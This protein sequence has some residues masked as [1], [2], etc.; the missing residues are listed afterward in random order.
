MDISVLRS[1]GIELKKH[2]GRKDVVALLSQKAVKAGLDPGALPSI[3]QVG[4]VAASG[5]RGRAAEIA[6][7]VR[8]FLRSPR[9]AQ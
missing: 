4:N 7:N 3:R 2:A 5:D 8:S 1:F 9:A 6:Q